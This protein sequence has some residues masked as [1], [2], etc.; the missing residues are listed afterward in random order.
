MQA[1]FT[2][3]H[4]SGT[5]HAL[6]RTR[7]HVC[8]LDTL[9]EGHVSSSCDADR[10]RGRRDASALE[11]SRGFHVLKELV[12]GFI[13]VVSG[14]ATPL[15]QGTALPAY[16]W[17][18]A[19]PGKPEMECPTLQPASHFESPLILSKCSQ[20]RPCESMYLI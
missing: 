18:G 9:A 15:P 2:S 13:S 4:V 16:D 20:G 6:A 14:D 10:V 17:S 12:S 19:R 3:Y 11:L 7:T 8:S 5:Q 1:A